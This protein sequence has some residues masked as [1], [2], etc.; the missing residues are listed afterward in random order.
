LP[1]LLHVYDPADR[2]GDQVYTWEMLA[3]L[4][5][6]PFFT[7]VHARTPGPTGYAKVLQS[8]WNYGEDM[9]ICEQDIVPSF[10]RVEELLKCQADF[11]AFDY[12]LS[13]GVPWTLCEGATGLGLSKI[14]KKARLR[15]IP[16]PA[17]P[18]H[19]HRDMPGL[20]AERLPPV[21]VHRP[22]VKHHHG[23]A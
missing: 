23:L 13:H 4:S 20:L 6:N 3:Y 14:S 9:V 11:C 1:L 19:A 15:I 8:L 5:G 10:A 21:H 18:Q 22:L 16:T 17:V 7:M 2:P 12:N